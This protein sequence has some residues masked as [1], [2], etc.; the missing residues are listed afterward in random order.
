MFCIIGRNNFAFVYRDSST[1][2]T[3]HVYAELEV[4]VVVMVEL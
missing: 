3:C 1:K 2:C 4:G